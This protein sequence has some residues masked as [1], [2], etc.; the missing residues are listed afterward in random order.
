[1]VQRILDMDTPE[2]FIEVSRD[3]I[4]A[5]A[6]TELYNSI[7]SSGMMLLAD[8]MWTPEELA[9]ISADQNGLNAALRNTNDEIAPTKLLHRLQLLG[10]MNPGIRRYILQ[11]LQRACV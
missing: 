7:V 3:L 9:S 8:S 4:T 1:M 10:Y 6:R 2:K 5:D 11:Y